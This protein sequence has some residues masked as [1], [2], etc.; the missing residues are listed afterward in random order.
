[1]HQLQPYQTKSLQY[2]QYYCACA[3]IL[4]RISLS[5]YLRE[6]S[7]RAPI[8]FYQL[9]HAGIVSSNTHNYHR[10]LREK[11]VLINPHPYTT[12]KRNWTVADYA[13]T[14]AA[15][16]NKA[17]MY[18]KA[19]EDTQNAVDWWTPTRTCMDWGA[20]CPPL[21][22]SDLQWPSTCHQRH[23]NHT[24]KIN[25]HTYMCMRIQV[26]WDGSNLLTQHNACSLDAQLMVH[27]VLLLHLSGSARLLH[28]LHVL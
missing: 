6:H 11:R 27:N 17:Y 20:Y 9:D 12:F 2:P 24:S 25:V 28:I 22:C 7:Q 14:D 1:M 19:C 13:H 16:D 18:H 21:N 10:G 23:N 3:C 26:S 8:Y 5:S 4:F 15:C